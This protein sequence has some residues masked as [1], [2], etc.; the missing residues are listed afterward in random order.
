MTMKRFDVSVQAELLRPVQTVSVIAADEEE[1]EA[2]AVGL[3]ENPVQVSVVPEKTKVTEESDVFYILVAVAHP[4]A[5]MPLGNLFLREPLIAPGFNLKECTKK[6]QNWIKHYELDESNIKEATVLKDNL[7]YCK[8]D[9]SG[10]CWSIEY[11][12]KEVTE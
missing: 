9:F 7:P 1:A 4:P 11:P 8:V 3:I 5:G 10:K 6:Y 12:N 2:L